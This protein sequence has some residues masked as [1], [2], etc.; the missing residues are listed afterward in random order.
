MAAL[1]DWL[2][3]AARMPWPVQVPFRM[4]PNLERLEAESPALLL[5]DELFDVYQR[6]RSKV[7]A[8]HPERVGVGVADSRVLAALGA[9]GTGI[10]TAHE[11]RVSLT[12]Q[13]DF[14]ILKHD[15]G[16]LRTEYLS[17][18]FPSRWDP[19]EKLGLDF[20]AI[21]QPVADNQMLQAAGPSLM[22]MAF[23][24][25]AMLRH[26]WLIVPN[27]ALD[28]HP[29]NNVAWWREAL[30]DSSPL[31]PRLYFRIERQTTWPLPQF[32][33]AVFF[34]RLLVSPLLNVVRVT[35]TRAAELAASLRSMSPAVVAYRGMSDA[36][37]RLLTEL[38][39]LS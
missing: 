20:M 39:G 23:M 28:Q 24:K 5:R 22:A 14:V 3:P 21:H 17:V 2:T 30:A 9:L 1:P 38:D 32:G 11:A 33:R 26:V 34:I 8:A 6:E 7:I 35:P 12:L 4:R 19:R 13:E 36:L 18:C 16:T 10:E 15:A 29:D 37:P 25:Q 31:L 27:P